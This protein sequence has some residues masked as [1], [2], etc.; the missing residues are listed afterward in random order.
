MSEHRTGRR[1][2][3]RQ[4]QMSQFV[5][6]RGS[7][8]AADLA[9]EFGVSVNTVHRDLDDLERR[10]MVRKFHGGVTAQP[11]GVFETNVAYRLRQMTAEKQRVARHAVRFVE[12]GMSLLL[13]DSTT[14]LQLIAHLGHRAPLKVAT[15]YLEAMHRLS[16]IDGVGLLAL[17]GEYDD[18][19]DAFLGVMCLGCIES[20]RVDACFISTS[21][22]QG[23]DAY[24]QEERV[25]TFK[26]AMLEA[27]ARRYLLLDHSKLGKVALHRLVPLS[28]FDAV[29]VDDG[30]PESALA[31]L[32]H[33]Q[34]PLEVA[35][36][37]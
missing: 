3:G 20:I 2:Q 18:Q 34:V 36:A 24:H 6:A 22:V 25:V 12:P 33:H 32:R 9:A 10:G 5:I 13:D 28:T 14:A 11:S 23:A 31:D 1:R 7:A 21:A 8:T 17:G 19:H 35:H 26:R 37:N 29:V 15:N 16:A 4:E 30:A 27:S